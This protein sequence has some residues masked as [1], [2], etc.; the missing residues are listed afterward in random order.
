MYYGY[1]PI[2][3]ICLHHLT[4]FCTVIDPPVRSMHASLTEKTSCVS[5]SMPMVL[6]FNCAANRCQIYRERSL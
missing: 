5:A 4:A 3:A 1:P 2:R 6:R